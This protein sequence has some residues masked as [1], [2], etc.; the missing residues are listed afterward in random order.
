MHFWGRIFVFFFPKNVHIYFTTFQNFF[1]VLSLTESTFFDTIILSNKKDV[2]SLAIIDT[3]IDVFTPILYGVA[4]AYFLSP[5]LDFFEKKLLRFKTKKKW[6]ANIKR[7]LAIL[8]TLV[9]VLLVIV[10]FVLIFVPQTVDSYRMLAK[11]WG[12]Y[13]DLFDENFDKYI[14]SLFEGHEQLWKIYE[15]VRESLGFDR[16]NPLVSQILAKVGGY[17]IGLLSMDTLVKFLSVGTTAF[18]VMIDLIYI[19]LLLIYLL[20]TKERQVARMRK[21]ARAFFSKEH[22]DYL[23]HVAQLADHK[24]GRYLRVQ[25]F[26]SILVGVVSYFVYMLFDIPFYPVLALIS[27]VT[28]IIPYFGPFI[29]AIPNAVFVVLAAPE[30]LIPFLLIVLVV[31]QLD[32]NVLVPILQSSNMKMDTFWVLVGMTIMGGIFGLPGMVLGVPVFSVIYILVKESAE[33]RLV[34]KSLSTDTDD[35][36]EGRIPKPQKTKWYK[37][38]FSSFQKKEAVPDL[39]QAERAEERSTE[40]F[41]DGKTEDPSPKRFEKDKK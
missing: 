22:A 35:Y 41:C 3:I 25:V 12:N 16:N 40:A 9:T 15:R 13:A 4:I 19:V 32:G 36:L 37:R 2:R 11:N 38:I 1:Q 14:D 34:A 23:E 8:L 6:Q 24:I 18:S 31:Q 29:G 28:N 39:P 7:V 26:D 10:A 20:F 17:L 27:G 30:K 21:L 5:L 33:K